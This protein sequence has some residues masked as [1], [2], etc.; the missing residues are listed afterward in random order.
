M[1]SDSSILHATQIFQS[2]VAAVSATKQEL[3]TAAEGV[4][5][6]QR[7]LE[8]WKRALD[9]HERKLVEART[10]LLTLTHEAEADGA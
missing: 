3:A 10:A 5:S 8:F 4:T 1:S 9:L 7:K 6:A 2:A